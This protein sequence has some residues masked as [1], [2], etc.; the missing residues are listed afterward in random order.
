MNGYRYNC[1]ALFH[2]FEEKFE[3]NPWHAEEV[4]VVPQAMTDAIIK[5]VN[6]SSSM[7][8][9]FGFIG[10][11]LVVDD[12]KNKAYYYNDVPVDYVHDSQFGKEPHYYTITLEY[13]DKKSFENPFTVAR[14]ERGDIEHAE[15]SNFLHPIIRRFDNGKKVAEHHVIE[16]LLSE[17]DAEEHCAPLK[18]FFEDQV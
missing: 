16:D 3:E 17:W 7:W 18:I 6:S 14:V 12:K 15:K 1:K 11:L 5:R 2:M 4:S 13:G 10:D 8:Q 9:Q